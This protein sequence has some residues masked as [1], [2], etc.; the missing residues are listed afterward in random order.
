MVKSEDAFSWKDGRIPQCSVHSRIKLEIL[1][2]YLLAYFPTITQNKRMDYTNI[3][4]VDAFSG[5]G[6]LIDAETK[7]PINGSPKVMIGAVRDS[8]VAIAAEKTKPF[9]INARYHFAD[10][11]PDAYRRL[12]MDLQ[13]S[14]YRSLIDSG[15]LFI[16]NMKF[17]DFLPRVLKRI[18]SHRRKKAIFF[19]DQCGWN[20]ATLRDCNRILQH[21][22]KA[23]I[24]WNISV[25]SLAMF[26]ND[27]PAFRKATESFGVELGDSLS[28]RE[29]SRTLSDWRKA[30]VAHYLRE[31]K[32]NCV[33]K[34]VSPFMVQHSG[35][36]YWLLHLSNHKE[37]NDVMKVTHWA[38]QNHS[39]H[40]GFP[41]LRMLEFNRENWKQSSF[42]RFDTDAHDSTLEALMCELGPQIS[43]LGEAPTVGGLIE[44]VANETPADRS[45]II[46]TLGNLHDA[47]EYRFVGPKG[48]KRKHMPQS[49]D[50]RIIRVPMR[51]VML[52]GMNN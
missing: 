26:A 3:E 41:G 25:E 40:E 39:L 50:D 51:S 47:D 37:A 13:Q 10:A 2:D 7:T 31:I 35:W 30:L 8:E 9:K 11:D 49:L 48:E 42:F 1:R 52:P 29:N 19:L 23:E 6:V 5:G 12:S 33:A 27:Q 44:S 34:F 45:R 21:L 43:S 4:L 14:D 17:C 24:I 38:H 16:D 36:G 18:P 22:P 20:Q 46:Q 28:A 32:S 15:Q